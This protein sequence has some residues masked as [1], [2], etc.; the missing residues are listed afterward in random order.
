SWQRVWQS[1]RADVAWRGRQIAEQGLQAALAS[2]HPA[3]RWS[4]STLQIDVARTL[5]VR[6]AGRG[7]TLLPS[8]FW[9]GRPMFGTHPD[10]SALTVSPSVTPLPLIDGVPGEAPLADLL[11]RTRAAVLA[12]AVGG[13]TTGE[14]A[15]EIGISPATA[16]QHAKTLRAAGLLVSERA[17][18]A[19]LHPA[20]PPA[21]RLLTG[22]TPHT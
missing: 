19:V 9:S 22:A 13:R 14:L 20:T 8:A 18:K 11:G 1:F 4:G 3:A 17:G 6:P 5:V 21:D 12:L 16:S 7:V 15:R 10:G 2:L